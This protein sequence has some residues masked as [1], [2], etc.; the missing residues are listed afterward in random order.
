MVKKINKDAN[1]IQ[2]FLEKG[3]NQAWIARKLGISKQKVNYW[4]KTAIKTVQNRRSKL[5]DEYKKK[6]IELAEDKLTSDMGSRKIDSK[7]ELKKEKKDNIDEIKRK[8]D[9]IGKMNMI[10]YLKYL[11]EKR[12]EKE[13]N[14]NEIIDDMESDLNSEESTIEDLIAKILKIK[15]I[16]EDKN[17]DISYKLNFDLKI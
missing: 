12:R 16:S 11:N 13:S 9:E 3:Y 1:A 7:G 17:N 8:I 10:E 14:Q 6:I 15:E 4:S 2:A 5:S